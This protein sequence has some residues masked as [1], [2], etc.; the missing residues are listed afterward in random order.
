MSSVLKKLKDWWMPIAKKIGEFQTKVILTILYFFVIGPISLIIYLFRGD[1]L[2]KRHKKS[3]SF[4]RK[5]LEP[6]NTL[7]GCQRQ[8]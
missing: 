8:F 3:T 5:E 1:L 4:W 2:K 7:E 6:V